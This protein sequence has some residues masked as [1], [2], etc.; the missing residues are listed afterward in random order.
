MFDSFV[1][2]KSITCPY[3]HKYDFR[4]TQSK[5]FDCL[6]GYFQQGTKAAYKFPI[7][8]YNDISHGLDGEI[9]GTGYSNPIPDGTFYEDDWCPKCTKTVTF[10]LTIKN[11]IFTKVRV[12]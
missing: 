11:G 5:Q 12:K 7:K 4:D 2:K 9:V 10:V 1:F 6:L 3:C 8:N